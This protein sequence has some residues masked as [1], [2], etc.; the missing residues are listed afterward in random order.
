M[1]C[2]STQLCLHTKQCSDNGDGH[3]N[4]TSVQELKFNFK[5]LFY[6]KKINKYS[7]LCLFQDTVSLYVTSISLKLTTQT[8]LASRLGQFSCT[9][10]Q[11]LILMTSLPF[12]FLKMSKIKRPSFDLNLFLP[13]I[14]E[15]LGAY[16][17]N[18]N[19]LKLL[20]N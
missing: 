4:Q 16:Q 11:R 2:P 8:M 19:L 5:L 10:S 14:Y 9:C 18:L 6:S 7:L 15:K 1:H 3:K 13:I 12:G 20:S 17:D